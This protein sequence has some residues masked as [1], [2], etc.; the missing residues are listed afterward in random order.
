MK[1][2]VI[3]TVLNEGSSISEVIDALLRQTHP[4]DEIVIVDG[5]SRDDTVSVL[6]RY[7]GQ[8]PQLKVYVDPGVNIAR[9]R[10]LAISRARGDII[11]VTD[12]GCRPEPD[13]LRE[14]LVPFENDPDVGAV[15]GHV[16]P[17]GEGRFEYYCGLLTIANPDNESQQGRFYGR[18]SAFLRRLWEQVGGYPEWLYTAEDT[19][20]SIRAR[21]LGFKIVYAP[22]S[23]VYWRPRPTLRK[24]AKMFYL[25]GRGNGRI[26]S[27]E[28]RGSWYWLKY[29]LALAAGL[30]A[31]FVEPWAFG[32]AGIA[33]V[34]LYRLIVAPNLRQANAGAD[35]SL[36]RFI[37]IPL[38]VL[39][40]NLSTN[41]G[42]VRGWMESRKGE[43]RDKLESYMAGNYGKQPSSGPEL[44]LKPRD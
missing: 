4:P 7:A 25:Y 24:M 18:S 20:F 38:I 43:F 33:A 35:A 19:L 8:Y 37:Y 13:W 28:V 41:L 23:K 32:I 39:V 30:L 2:S 40:R 3:L 31:G 29:Y 5:G 34:Q 27:G 6:R 11:A 10:N 21:K 44:D 14:F 42:F 16:I 1:V 9:G 17:R 26:Q 22:A 12:G 15:A 36:D